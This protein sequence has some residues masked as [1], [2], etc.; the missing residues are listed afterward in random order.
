MHLMSLNDASLAKVC[1]LMEWSYEPK[2]RNFFSKQYIINGTNGT[3]SKSKAFTYKFI[4]LLS[5][6]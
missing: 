5:A 1:G 6:F 2:I 4:N 3:K